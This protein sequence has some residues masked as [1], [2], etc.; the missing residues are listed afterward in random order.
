V[1]GHVDADEHLSGGQGIAD[2]SQGAKVGKRF[3]ADDH[4]RGSRLE[5][6]GRGLP[7]A[8]SRVHPGLRPE[9]FAQLTNDLAMVAYAGDGV[10]VSDV[11]ASPVALAAQ[12]PRD[13]QRVAAGDEPAV[14]GAVV[15]PFTA[16]P[17]YHPTPHEV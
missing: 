4:S 13:R 10:K 8:D 12:S 16:Q 15:L 7:A 6:P 9:T 2:R 17:L 5:E 1:V 14:H 11:Q 3:G